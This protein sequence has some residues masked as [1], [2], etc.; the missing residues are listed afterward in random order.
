MEKEIQ[1]LEIEKILEPIKAQVEKGEISEEQAMGLLSIKLG[2]FSGEKDSSEYQ[3]FKE[4]SKIIYANEQFLDIA[5]KLDSGNLYKFLRASQQDIHT[6]FKLYQHL[7]GEK[8]NSQE[9]LKQIMEKLLNGKRILE[10][11]CGP[12]FN[13]KVLQDLGAKPSGVEILEGL[14]NRIPEV[15]V[16]Y[17]DAENLDNLF[18]NEK[19][20]IIYSRDLFCMNIMD[21]EKANKINKQIEKHIKNGGIIIHQITYEKIDLSMHLLAM[22]FY[23]RRKNKNFKTMEKEFWDQSKE[24]RESKLYTNELALDPQEI[25]GEGFKLVENSVENGELNIILKK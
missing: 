3:K 17:G 9:K 5:Y 6:L 14:T 2:K 15:D 22:W 18:G 24:K 11:G 7:S 8:Y 13:L 10:L 21:R 25:I 4:N 20:D 19:F 23:S 12:G 1:R 16:R